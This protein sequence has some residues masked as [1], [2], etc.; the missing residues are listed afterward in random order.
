MARNRLPIVVPCQRIVAS[1][2]GL[3]GFGRN[4]GQLD[5]KRAL[6]NLEAG[7]L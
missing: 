4:A 6:L 2:G 5:L 3:G 1:D 7:R